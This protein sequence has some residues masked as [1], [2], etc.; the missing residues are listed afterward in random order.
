MTRAR[1]LADNSQG[2]KPK[3]VDAKG[4]L[5]VG[6][7]AD[8]VAA[9]GV[10]GPTGSVL[11]I[12][13]GETTGLKWDFPGKVL[14]VVS[15][16]STSSVSW[17]DNNVDRLFFE[18]TITPKSS[19]STMYVIGQVTGIDNA[20]NGRVYILLKYSTSSGGTSGTN[21]GSGGTLGETAQ[22]SSGTTGISHLP[23]HDSVALGN[24][25]T[26][27]FKIIYGKGDAGGT[28]YLN[29]YNGKSMVTVFEVEA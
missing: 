19:T 18:V 10:T 8:T 17:T 22:N 5:L 1:D 15:N 7:A 16:S 13:A 21:M 6:T 4:D 2:S 9:L 11:T 27:Y 28:N 12:N 26:T 25:T 14:Q 3:I 24:T 23:I 20:G 29:R